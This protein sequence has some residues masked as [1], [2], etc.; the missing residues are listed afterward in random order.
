MNRRAKKAF[1][2]RQDKKAVWLSRDSDR[3]EEASMPKQHILEQLHIGSWEMVPRKYNE[4]N[5]TVAAWLNK[6]VKLPPRL[7]W[8]GAYRKE[9]DVDGILVYKNVKNATMFIQCGPSY[10]QILETIYHEFL[11]WYLPDV[12]EEGI[13]K[14]EE[15]IM[16]RA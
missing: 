7:I 1:R 16:A 3:R 14:L 15:T 6:D 10:G 4:I 9:R 2:N 13:R 5:H 11:H 8:H 12:R